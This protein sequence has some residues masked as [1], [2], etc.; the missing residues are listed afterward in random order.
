MEPADH[1]GT[2]TAFWPQP[3]DAGTELPST[4]R[5]D[6][7]QPGLP[8]SEST[9][10]TP[11]QRPDENGR[12]RI[13]PTDFQAQPP[14]IPSQ[15]RRTLPKRGVS[16]ATRTV[17]SVVQHAPFRARHSRRDRLLQCGHA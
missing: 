6:H 14:L 13:A 7:R 17:R 15:L 16:P 2:W 10:H 9:V 1:S 11:H 4:R 3:G 5:M 12:R 8:V